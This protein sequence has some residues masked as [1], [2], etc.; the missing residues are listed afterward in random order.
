MMSATVSL[1]NDG[2]VGSGPSIGRLAVSALILGT[3]VMPG[4]VSGQ[5]IPYAVR[6]GAAFQSY[7]LL[8]PSAVGIER[9]SLGTLS[10]GASTRPIDPLRLD[11]S[12]A[13]ARGAL[14]RT[15]GSTAAITGLTDTEIRAAVDL[16]GDVVTVGLGYLLPTGNATQTLEEIEVA[17]ALASDLLPFRIS[18]WGSG[19]AFAM[20]G[21]FASPVAGFGVGLRVSYTLRRPFTPLENDPPENDQ[22]EDDPWRYQ[23]GNELRVQLAADR[24]IGTATKAA[25][26]VDMQHY[27]DD[28]IAGER[29]YQAGDWLQATGSI[30]FPAGRR[31]SGVAFLSVLHRGA[32]RFVVETLDIPARDLIIAGTAVRVPT[33][34]GVVMP[35]LDVRIFRRSDGLGQGVLTGL[36]VSAELPAGSLILVPTLRSRFGKLLKIGRA[37]V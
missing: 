23:P 28:A 8:N 11:L 21:L 9:L 25:L 33:D 2:R 13:Y 7:D 36:G 3:F 29:A 18:S 20:S 6:A 16:P 31:S 35:S 37:H 34:H 26:I 1:V 10:F 24:T 17:G 27:G 4:V 5:R 30:S 19:G 22:A 14:M 15:D 12:G 32:G